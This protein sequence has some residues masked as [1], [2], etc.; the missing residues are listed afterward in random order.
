MGDGERARELLRCLVKKD[1]AG[2]LRTIGQAQ[3]E[4]LDLR[5]LDRA[6]VASLRD[7]LLVLSGCEKEV[8]LTP[9]DLAEVK[10]L[11]QGASLPQVLRALRL[12]G[13]AEGAVGQ[14]GTLPLE[15][16]LVDA[17]V[18]AAPPPAPV[19]EAAPV[20]ALAPVVPPPKPVAEAAP[21]KPSA[22]PA[23]QAVPAK[24]EAVPVP[25]PVESTV[26]PAPPVANAAPPKPVAKPATPPPAT[27]KS[28]PP[29][30]GTPTAGSPREAAGMP[31]TGDKL[32]QL[33]HNW[34][35][36]IEQAPMPVR[37]SPAVAILR[38]AGVVPVAIENGTVT[39]S[40]RHNFHKEKIE[41]LEN[42][43]VVVGLI[44]AFFGQPCQVKCIYEPNENHLVREAQKLGAQVV[45]VEEK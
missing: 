18:E 10:T 34:R 4:G 26:K 32:E 3:A 19:R 45:E 25:K 13:E 8:D 12:F 27:P 21:V 6:L 7:L 17:T 41:E 9:D 38:S 31:L 37:R 28:E 39:L 20:R 29:A 30:S 2:G 11:A 33:K 14:G 44:S 16:A 23:A 36:I 5:Q 42:R 43:K 24:P 1:A 15:L 40:F 35:Q 22:V